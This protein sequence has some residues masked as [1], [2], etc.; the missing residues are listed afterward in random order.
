MS[1]PAPSR[2]SPVIAAP[3]ASVSAL[4]PS[5]LRMAIP[6]APA[7]ASASGASVIVV[8]LPAALLASIAAPLPPCAMAVSV[9]LAAAEPRLFTAIPLTAPLALLTV[10]AIPVALA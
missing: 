9:M 5:L 7:R 1:V 4:L 2:T 10:S 3:L 8:R 6:D